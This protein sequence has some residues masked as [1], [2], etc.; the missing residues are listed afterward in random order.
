MLE[1]PEV[2]SQGSFLTTGLKSDKFSVAVKERLC[3]DLLRLIHLGYI[4]LVVFAD[5]SCF[6]ETVWVWRCVGVCASV[7]VPWYKVRKK[8]TMNV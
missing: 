3:R 4:N 1:D 5:S 2:A 6:T 8:C 7:L